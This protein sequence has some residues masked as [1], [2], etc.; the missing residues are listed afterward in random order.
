MK[1]KKLIIGT[2]AGVLVAA[3][4]FS[5]LT[6]PRMFTS[7]AEATAA[8]AVEAAP[9]TAAEGVLV[10][11]RIASLSLLS[12]GRV[13]EIVVAEGAQVA[14]GQLI[15]RV[16]DARQ[17]AGVAQAEAALQRAQARLAELKAG[18]LPGEVTVARTAVD[19][20]QA[21]LDR[22]AG[23]DDIRGAEAA[24][25]S[26]QA[27]LAKLREGTAAGQLIAA[28]ADLKNAEAAVA[29]AQAAYDRVR[30]NPDIAARP[31]SLA[32]QQATNSFNA[33]AARLADL[34]RGASGADL[35][36]ARARV[37]QAQAQLDALKAARPSDIAAA[38]AELRRAQAQ[39]DLTVSGARPE[40]IAAA[41]ADVAAAAAA[42]SQAKAALAETELRAPFAGVL[43]ELRTAVGQQAAPGVAL[44][45]LADTANWQIETTD[46]TELD[47]VRVKDGD[48]VKITFDA[49]P[50]E[51]IEGT[52]AR[53]K[54]I[55]Q[56][57]K[58]E[59]SYTAIIVPEK[60]D[61]RL[62]WN[63]TAVVEF[64]R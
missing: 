49:L 34:E 11:S 6:L 41:E 3:G 26:A 43:A 28:R 4:V 7:A 47:V 50:G 44:A 59:I 64:D 55:G 14:A 23:R 38:Q 8:P 1:S 61:P 40:V 12:G 57:Q 27:A 35:A 46:L 25:A 20:A 45:Q 2:I 37:D 33:A 39:L 21:R 53:I 19:L 51:A 62:R 32:L 15:L 9:R 42:L 52:V 29:Q 48:P 13:T 58:G 30:G 18:A 60:I 5:A 24:L 31:E 36:G 16:E 17:V 22:L 54:G 56:N 63:M 10:P